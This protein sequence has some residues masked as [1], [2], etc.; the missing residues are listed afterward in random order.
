M[1]THP[2]Y[3]S[4]KVRTALGNIV[5]GTESVAGDWAPFFT[6]EAPIRSF[7]MSKGVNVPDA[8]HVAEIQPDYFLHSD[9]PFDTK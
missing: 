4:Q 3:D 5:T 1:L 9:S 8:V 7:Y 6:A 2:S